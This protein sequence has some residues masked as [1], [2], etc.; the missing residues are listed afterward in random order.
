M[1]YSYY[2]TTLQHYRAT[3]LVHDFM[4]LPVTQTQLQAHDSTAVNPEAPDQAA[5]QP[6]SGIGNLT[7]G[8][9]GRINIACLTPLPNS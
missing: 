6:A 7:A 8:A 1:T 4:Y 3:L 2:F 5:Q 9:G